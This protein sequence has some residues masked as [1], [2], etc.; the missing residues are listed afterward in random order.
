MIALE[1]VIPVHKKDANKLPLVVDRLYQHTRNLVHVHV[2][3]P[4]PS[5]IDPINGVTIYADQDVFPFDTSKFQFRPNWVYQQF[6]KLFS[7]LTNTTWF[8]SCDC[9]IFL[10]RALGFFSQAN[11][12]RLFRARDPNQRLNGYRKFN[13]WAFGDYPDVGFS[14]MNDIALYNRDAIDAMLYYLHTDRIGFADNAAEVIKRGIIPAE[15]EVYAAWY[16]KSMIDY[17]FRYEFIDI[18]NKWFGVYSDDGHVWESEEIDK[19]LSEH[20]IPD[21]VSIHSWGP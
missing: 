14:V 5:D 19:I 16:S 9:D 1:A 17:K 7:D 10:N 4:D 8:L 20:T 12:P 15:A 6:I 2:V 11:Q 3:T 18:T 21:T 13:E